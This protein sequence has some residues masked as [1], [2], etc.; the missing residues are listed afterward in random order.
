MV[1]SFSLIA[2]LATRCDNCGM[3]DASRRYRAIALNDVP[4]VENGDVEWRPIRHTLDITAFGF[5]GYTARQAGV[6]VVEAHDETSEGSGKHEEL[7]F[8]ASGAVRFEVDGDVL[9]LGVGRMVLVPAGVRRRAVAT[10]DDTT[11]LVVG[12]RS[13]SALPP[14]PFEYWYSAEPAYQR[15]DFDEAVTIAEEGLV[16][17]PEHPHLNYQL[18]CFHSR[19]GRAGDALRHLAIAAVDPEKAGW[20]QDDA[21]FD[22][23]RADARFPAAP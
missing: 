23:I 17:Y 15:G 6:E 8:I 22:A 19:A 5:N 1:G 11:V 18:A 14:S 20:A 12:G 2:A 13:G 3:S 10:A 9:D 7:Y 21:D 16:S 4:R